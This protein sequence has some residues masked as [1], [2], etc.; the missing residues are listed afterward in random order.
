M[1]DVGPVLGALLA[2]TLVVLLK[3][4]ALIIGFKIIKLGYNLLIMG[5][6]GEFKFNADLLGNKAD[7]RSASPGLLFL[8]LGCMLCG[9]VV[10]IEFE[11]NV[12]ILTRHKTT[13]NKMPKLPPMINGQL[14]D[15]LEK[16]K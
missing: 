9:W 3:L 4:V 14:S 13:N 16:K 2:G 11:Q 7:L 10:S 15:M 8:L 1:I 12:D 5:V 6:K